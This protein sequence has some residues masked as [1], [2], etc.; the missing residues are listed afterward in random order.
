MAPLLFLGD[1][2][3]SS[4]LKK[5]KPAGEFKYKMKEGIFI[6]QIS[7]EIAHILHD[8]YNVPW[9]DNGISTTYSVPRKYYLC[10]SGRNMALYSKLTNPAK[11]N[12]K[13]NKRVGV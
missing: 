12:S 11:N 9:K 13:R 6:I 1:F 7:K 4:P 10:E 3:L 2:R 5:S 8:K